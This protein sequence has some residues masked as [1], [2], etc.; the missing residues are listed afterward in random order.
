MDLAC[1]PELRQDAVTAAD[2]ARDLKA[3]QGHKGRSHPLEAARR[4]DHALERTVI[5]LDDVVE[6][7]RGA[8]LDILRQQ[9]SSCRRRIAFGYDASLSVVI[10]NGGEPL[11]VLRVLRRKRW[12]APVSRRSD[13]MK[14][15]S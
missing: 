11:I 1:R 13:S 5:G 7:L 15:I 2:H 9:A 10:D 14:S 3:L 6:I 8:L 12:V 4:P